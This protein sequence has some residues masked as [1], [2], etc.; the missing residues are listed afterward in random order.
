MKK[1]GLLLIVF[2][3]FIVACKNDKTE[4]K[5]PGIDIDI[6]P[7]SLALVEAD[8]AFGI[9][10][11]QQIN[12]EAGPTE[13]LFVSPTSVGLA[14][15]MT[16]NGAKNETKEAMEECMQ[17]SG[18]SAQEI[19]EVY[20]NLMQGLV[21]ADPDVAFTV[22]N[23]IWYEQT[24]SVHPDFLNTN[25]Q[26]YGAEVSPLDFGDPASVDAINH[27]VAINTNNKIETIIDEI[28][29]DQVMFL[30]NAI[31]FKGTWQYEFD[32]A[33]TADLPFFPANGTP[34]DVPTMS[35]EA[36]LETYSNGMFQAVKLPYG[37]GSFYM[38]VMLP[39]EP[40]SVD[41]LI[42]SL[43]MENW[44]EWQSSFSLTEGFELYLPKF[45]F[46][47]ETDLIPALT[48]MGMGIAFTGMADFSGISDFGPLFINMVKHK[49]FVDVNEEGTE[50]AAVTIVGIGYTSVNPNL[51]MVNRP[52]LFT[53]C[54]E[55]TGAIVFMG[56]VVLPVY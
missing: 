33:N 29:Y 45:K 27:W 48:Q 51:M 47:Y 12:D 49:T 50:A 41:D 55:S 54:E 34:V 6:N 30:I 40:N 46:E 26:Y 7:K 42:A 17:V 2:L 56:K 32:P 1:I 23:S 3:G 4:P 25:I 5:P 11:F 14:L 22:A 31:Y 37:N 20:Q 19:N 18:L 24:F 44:S 35:L 13:N 52:F 15:A 36:D 38:T 16:Y 8:N 10:L 21:G 28:G 43:T 9:K 39:N 53:I